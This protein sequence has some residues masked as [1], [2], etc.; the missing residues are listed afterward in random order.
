MTPTPAF[1]PCN[2]EM[3][4]KTAA[5]QRKDL[6]HTQYYKIR[7]FILSYVFLLFPLRLAFIL[8][9]LFLYWA[10]LR[11]V[12]LGY[13][14][15]LYGP[16]MREEAAREVAIP[17]ARFLMF[18]CGVHTITRYHVTEDELYEHRKKYIKEQ[19]EGANDEIPRKDTR[20]SYMV[21][22]NHHAFWDPAVIVSEFGE[23]SFVVKA[24]LATAPILGKLLHQLKT[25][26]AGKGG[27]ID[28]INKRVK[29]YYETKEKFSFFNLP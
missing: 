8:L 26:F 1:I 22:S 14:L 6:T 20:P 29:K 5:F 17:G 10:Y 13:F 7:S 2:M 25:L 21:V 28:E 15:G 19:E 3:L 11:V 18:N 4:Q 24:D 27:V 16:E 12:D 23:C 9:T